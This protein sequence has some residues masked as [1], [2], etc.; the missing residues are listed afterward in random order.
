MGEQGEDEEDEEDENLQQL[1]TI[2]N[3]SRHPVDVSLASDKYQSES[4]EAKSVQNTK[5]RSS[6]ISSTSSMI[7]NMLLTAKDRIGLSS[8][9]PTTSNSS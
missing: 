3:A 9:D 4:K 2:Q 6:S 5:D 8:K 7:A 1:K